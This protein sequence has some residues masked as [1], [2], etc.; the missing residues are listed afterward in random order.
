[1]VAL[2]SL[3]SQEYSLREALNA[4]RI[5]IAGIFGVARHGKHQPRA[6]ASGVKGKT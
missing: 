4:I 2:D 1:M 5:L 3:I 6:N